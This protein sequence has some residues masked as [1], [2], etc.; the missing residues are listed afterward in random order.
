MNK[1]GWV[2]AGALALMSSPA[3]AHGHKGAHRGETVKMDEL[4]AAVQNTFRDESKDGKVEEIRKETKKNG[5]VTYEGEVV[6]NGTGTELVVDADGKVIHRGKAHDE[7]KE[8]KEE[9]GEKGEK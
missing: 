2:L 7:S 4:P 1:R 5:K 8:M 3:L 6:K 9:K